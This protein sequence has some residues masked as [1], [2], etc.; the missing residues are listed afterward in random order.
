MATRRT[1]GRMVLGLLGIGLALALAARARAQGPRPV[2]LPPSATEAPAAPAPIPTQPT[3]APPVPPAVDARLRELEAANQRLQKQVEQLTRSHERTQSKEQRRTSPDHQAG[4]P[5]AFA[6]SSLR[7]IRPSKHEPEEEEP[8]RG[9]YEPNMKSVNRYIKTDF[10][11]G[12][13][14]YTADDFF[15]LTFHNLTQAEFRQFSPEGDPLHSQFFVPRQRWYFEGKVSDYVNYYTVIN[16]GYASLDV[17]DAWADINVDR[18]MLQFR[19]GRMKTPFTYEYI[20][21]AENDL[22]APERS[23]FVGNFATNRQ[24]G[25]MA[26]GIL[27]DD[28]LEYAFG[29]FNG[30]RRS[31]QDMNSPMDYIAFVNTRPFLHSDIP[32]LANLNLGGSFLYGRERN[33]LGPQALRTAN[34]QSGGGGVALLSPTFLAYNE[35]VFENGPRAQWSA[36]V[37]YYYRSLGILLGYQ[38]G[39]ANYSFSDKPIPV[40]EDVLLGV[41]DFSGTDNP[42]HKSVPMVGWNVAVFYFITGEQ[43]TRRRHLLEPINHFGLHDGHW[44]WG[45]VELFG[46]FSNLQLGHQVFSYGFADPT[47]WTNRASTTDIG[48][49][50]YWNHYIKFT[51]DWQHAMYGSPVYLAPGQMTRHEDLFWFRTQIFF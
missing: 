35:K 41:S 8:Q 1:A 3:L 48:F 34:D 36:D 13:R 27:L 6:G 50:W 45:A 26:H 4:A 29:V 16:R 28:R 38:G 47:L 49:N 11:N 15:D 9:P 33:I 31:F 39:F 17:L 14:W 21:I 25:A 43:V 24:I 23:L 30:P 12:L 51:F 22:I 20:K 19:V 32:W 2:F 5:E 10:S 7:P 40:P 44:G 18:K 37:T 42:V 46:R